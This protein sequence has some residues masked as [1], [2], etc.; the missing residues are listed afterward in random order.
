M[1][2]YQ[3]VTIGEEVSLVLRVAESSDK[4]TAMRE[5]KQWADANGWNLKLRPDHEEADCIIEELAPVLNLPE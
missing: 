2:I 3:L 1:N 4:R 5:L